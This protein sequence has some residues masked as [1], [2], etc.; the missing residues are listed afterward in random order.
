MAQRWANISPQSRTSGFQYGGCL[1]VLSGLPQRVAW[2]R[3]S[4]AI[5]KSD[6][7]GGDGCPSDETVDQIPAPPRA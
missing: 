3:K 6:L 5:Q 2:G 4:G 7:W 1:V